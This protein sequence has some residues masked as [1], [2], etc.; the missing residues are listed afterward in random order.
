MKYKTTKRKRKSERSNPWIVMRTQ[1]EGYG[2]KYSFKD[3]L[4][5][6]IL[7]MAI[8]VIVGAFM[9]LEELYT[10]IFVGVVLIMIPPMIVSQYRYIYEEKRFNDL[11][12]YM[13][14]M[15]YSFKKKPKIL[16]ALEDTAE[17]ST[18]K[19][20][21]LINQAIYMIEND[22]SD[23]VYREALRLIE[24]EYECS[25]IIQLHRFLCKVEEQ[26]GEYNM[27]LDI[28]LDDILSWSKRTFVFQK[29]RADI[30]S[31]I[32]LSLVISLGICATTLFMVPKD[33]V[34]TDNPIYQVCTTVVLCLFV[35][36]Y[37]MTQ[38]TLNASW[39]ENDA[40]KDV[41]QI[42]KDLSV[43][44]K[45]ITQQE[46]KNSQ[47]ATII[48]IPLALFGLYMRNIPIFMGCLL[49]S[50]ILYNKP[51]SRLK[52]ATK[53]TIREIEKEFPGWCRDISIN[54]QTENVYNSIVLSLDNCPVILE[55]AVKKLILEI[56][57][58][59]ASVVPYN[60]F[61]IEFNIPEIARMMKT[62]Y[63]LNEYGVQDADSQISKIIVQNNALLEK[64][65]MLKN[66]D[67]L[68]GIKFFTLVPMFLGSCKM[69]VDLFLLCTAFMSIANSTI[70]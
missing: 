19:M 69:M 16:T 29:E 45:G 27:A 46:A 18:G 51:R 17:I 24:K 62:L 53:R 50:F 5:V 54:L 65:E 41:E 35:G 68:A 2:F 33:L 66:E 1:I 22:Y 26:G 14:Q 36:I 56:D 37:T 67:S 4:K 40:I 10:A 57:E 21:K 7:F 23:N 25:R 32:M 43:A 31:K 38:T 63:S 52:N 61:L 30:K 6:T 55:D 11:T 42:K 34:I 39:L 64:A 3:F 13:E 49:L 59:P 15:S 47:I 9:K 20:N 58:M 44:L 48:P 60:N 70:S 8:M 12:I 28:L